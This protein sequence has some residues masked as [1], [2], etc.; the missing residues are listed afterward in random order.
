MT[1]IILVRHGYSEGNKEK[2][3]SG[4]MDVPLSQVGQRQAEQM[5]EYVL[6]NY[7]VHAV[8]AS[9]LCRAYDTV[10]PIAQALGLTV[11]AR[12]ALRE[13]DVGLW[14]GM[15]IED[16][17]VKYPESFSLYRSKPGLARFDGGESYGDMLARVL[18]EI[19]RIA[20]KN[21]GKTVIVGTHGGVIRVLRAFWMGI[22]MEEIETIAHVPNG[23]ITAVEYEKCKASITIAGFCDYLSERV[24]EEGVK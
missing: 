1:R 3:F 5:S 8:Y 12:E 6:E 15:L 11:Q 19:Q 23:S 17:R 14:Q 7:D 24:T 16:V 20:E 4:Q 21:E 18:P 22:P 13:V 2:R 9:D 10:K